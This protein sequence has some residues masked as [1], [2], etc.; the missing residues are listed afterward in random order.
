MKINVEQT[1]RKAASLAKK[2]KKIEAGNLYYSVLQAFPGN[3]RAKQS[4]EALGIRAS[5]NKS[6]TVL[7]E[8]L[9][10]LW[11]LFNTKAYNQA[12]DNAKNILKNFPA[13]ADVWNVLG[14]SAVRIKRLDEA[15]EAFNQI[16]EL[17][18]N[19]STGYINL[20]NIHAELNNFDSALDSYAQAL[21]IKSDDPMTHFNKGRVLRQ[22]GK[23][24]Q[25]LDSYHRA[26]VLN[27]KHTDAFINI[28][29]IWMLMDNALEAKQAFQKAIS[30]DPHSAIA[31]KNLGVAFMAE[32]N[33]LD[34][35]FSFQRAVQLRPDYAEA[36]AHLLHQSQNI[37]DFSVYEK[38]SLAAKTLGISTAAVDPFAALSWNDDAQQ[39]LLRSQNYSRSKHKF[40][41]HSDHQ[42]SR[43]YPKRLRIGYFSADFH[44]HATL[45]LMAGL[46]REHDKNQFEIFIYSYG[47]NKEGKSRKD[48]LTNSENF[49]DVSQSSDA[50]IERLAKSHKLHIAID[51]KG[52]TS[53][54]RTQLFQYGLAPIQVNYLGYPGTLGADFFDYLVADQIVIPECHQK[55]YSEKII[56]MPHT[57]Q[58][59]DDA[60]PK[61][62][63]SYGREYFAL[64]EDAFVFCCFN[65]NYKIS[66]LEYD[67][68]MRLLKNVEGSVLWLL[69]SNE[70]AMKNLKKEAETRG[71]D[72]SRVIFAN[73]LPQ[74]DHIARHKNADIF[75]D[76]FAYN[77]HT[78]AS[79]ALWAGLPVVTKMGHQFSARVA[80]SLLTAAGLKELITKTEFDYEKKCLELALNPKKL[81]FIKEK[82]AKNL[83][84][85][86]LFDTKRYARNFERGLQEAYKRLVD[87]KNPANIFV[88]ECD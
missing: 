18:P 60:R 11:A 8:H 32:G 65:N 78:T 63:T 57:Y 83:N 51:L 25:A 43:V 75:L 38:I 44:D 7:D 14:I 66:P 2:G 88:K 28:G 73:K 45:Y 58:S 33:I 15:I 62:Q 77:A 10:E 71:V 49:H 6:T 76:T 52:Y 87:G 86:P 81:K 47:N 19:D 21:S 68:W 27:P 40:A 17:R 20:G 36:E 5:D 41:T 22:L 39:Q 1:L 82:L 56:Y 53:K 72:P 24:Q 69:N 80:A 67:I 42:Q 55:Y 46:L 64:P 74:V 3:L 13:A 34:S 35:I 54:S 70:W 84:T 30:V 12:I 79:D 26:I 16:I 29:A 50:E 48:L 23:F 4:L 85:Q 31:H 9:E 59:T 61:P 37:C